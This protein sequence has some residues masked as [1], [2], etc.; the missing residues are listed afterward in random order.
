M[1]DIDLFSIRLFLAA[2][3]EGSMAKAA[4]RENI[5]PSAISKRMSELEDAFGMPLLERGVKGVQTT[6]AGQALV[7]H[8][9]M[10]TLTTQRMHREMEGYLRGVRGHIRLAAS[11]ASLSGDLPVDIQ[12]FRRAHPQIELALEER[13]THA[14]FRSV[15]E[16]TADV[17]IGS[18]FG[19]HDGLQ[20][21][22]YSHCELSAIVPSDHPLADH[23][24]V[25]YSQLLPFDQIELNR[26]NGISSIFENAALDA[27]VTRRISARVG[28]HETICTLVGRGMGVA[29]VPHYLQ[30]LRERNQNVCFVPLSGAWS[31]TRICIAVRDIATLPGPA[32]AFVAHLRL[33]GQS[34]ALSPDLRPSTCL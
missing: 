25:S 18:D 3:E 10:L 13:T 15:L 23:A 30:A 1:R 26:P 16:G 2:V 28:S 6:P 9:R 21:F 5:V 11:V 27:K 8:A 29:V 33:R 7:F 17:G 20:V 14:V 4:A 24:S 31:S 34:A 22:P 32:Q 19:G 12:S